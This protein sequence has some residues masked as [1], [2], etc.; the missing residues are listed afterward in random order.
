MSTGIDLINKLEKGFLRSLHE[1]LLE[2]LGK[3]RTEGRLMLMFYHEERN[4][5]FGV[6]VAETSFGI[7]TLNAMSSDESKD[8]YTASSNLHTS[9]QAHQMIAS[10]GFT[11]LGAL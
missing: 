4:F 3:Q 6:K 9:L 7:V 2:T 8:I 1:S 11:L 5:L 10:K